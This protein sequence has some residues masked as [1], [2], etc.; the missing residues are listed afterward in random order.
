M[1]P[2]G[3]SALLAVMA[4]WSDRKATDPSSATDG[5]QLALNPARRGLSDVAAMVLTMS[6]TPLTRLY[7]KTL[8]RP[9]PLWARSANSPAESQATNFPLGLIAG[10][11]DGSGDWRPPAFSDRRRVWF[12]SRSRT[13]TSMTPLVSPGTRLEASEA[14]TT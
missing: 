3:S 8:G 7:R 6:T 14:N 10:C 11:R 2:T 9:L 5:C 4:Y 13:K 12:F 1:A